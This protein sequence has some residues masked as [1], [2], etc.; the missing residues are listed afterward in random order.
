MLTFLKSDPQIGILITRHLN[1]HAVT[2]FVLKVI[3]AEDMPDGEGAL[4]WLRDLG[5]IEHLF[6]QLDPTLEAESHFVASQTLIDIITLTYQVPDQSSTPQDV[7]KLP[8][9]ASSNLLIAE[10]KSYLLI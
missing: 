5:L 4:S 7:V 8:V 2:D 10:M 9:L 6:D 3:N 1:C